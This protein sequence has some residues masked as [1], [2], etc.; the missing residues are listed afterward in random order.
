ML[1]MLLLIGLFSFLLFIVLL[2]VLYLVSPETAKGVAGA[3][4]QPFIWC[5]YLWKGDK[6]GKF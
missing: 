6:N 3:L 4:F 1:K 2:G 5:Y